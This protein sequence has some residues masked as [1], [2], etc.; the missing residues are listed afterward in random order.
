[1]PG[2]RRFAI[3]RAI[4]AIGVIQTVIAI[5]G[6]A[7]VAIIVKFYGGT[8]TNAG[9][10]ISKWTGFLRA[11]PLLPLLV[12]VFWTIGACW[13]QGSGRDNL[14]QFMLRLGILIIALLV[15]A[16]MVAGFRPVIAPITF[17]RMT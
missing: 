14:T 4:A 3:T 9:F 11:N 12:P 13:F 5:T 7:A 1:M 17:L 2:P 8:E 15:A 10:R 16:F 6:W